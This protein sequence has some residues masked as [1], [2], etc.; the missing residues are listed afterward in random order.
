[1]KIGDK[2]NMLK[3]LEYVNSDKRGKRFLFKCD[4]GEE[5]VYHGAYVKGGRYKTC[6]CIKYDKNKDCDILK[7]KYHRLKPIKRVKNI[8]RGRAFLCRCDCGNQKI[9][10]LAELKRGT[11]K[12]CGCW[13]SEVQSSFMI[14]YSTKHGKSNTPEYSIWK[15]MKERCNNPKNKSYHNY[16]GRGIKVFDRWLDS[17]ENFIND[18]G[19]RP[20][21]NHQ[22]DRINNDGNYEPSNCKWST[23]SENTI[24]K[25]HKLG[26]SGHKNIVLDNKIKTEN[27]YYT[28]IKRKGKTRTSFYTILEIA[29]KIK[30]KWL[31]EYEN[32]PDKWI[33]DTINNNYN[34]SLD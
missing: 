24:N 30:E 10:S 25:R 21:K 23:R 6:G 15:G 1:M 34:K 29:L 8:R 20:S 5:V 14:D 3:C 11:T 12:S 9:I 31:E 28:M 17:F 4:C 32:N 27:C 26:V 33:E 16:G 13:N 22:L 2:Y 7:T 19:E 18:M